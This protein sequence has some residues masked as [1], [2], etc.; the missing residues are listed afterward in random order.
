[1][2]NAPAQTATLSPPRVTVQTQDFDTAAL[3]SNLRQ[4]TAGQAGA[5]VTFIGYVRDYTPDAPTHTLFLD[6]YP[7]MCEREITNLCQTA[8]QGWNILDC[9]VVLRTGELHHTEQIVYVGVTS[10]HRGQAFQAS[11][12]IIDTLKTRT[13]FWKRETLDSGK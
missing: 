9:E 13:P 7:G 10:A 4:R 5:V 12:N 3:T 11:E 2:V 6:H 1:N 8:M